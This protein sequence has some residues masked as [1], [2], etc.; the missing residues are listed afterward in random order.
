MVN[1]RTINPV[2]RATAIIGAVAALVAGV[3]FAALTSTAT[4]TDTTMSSTTAE[5]L[6][7]DGDSFDSTAPG[8]TV[9]DL[10]P[11][12]GSG[13]LPFYF[14]NN[15]GVALDITARVPALPSTSGITSYG[16]IEV[17]IDGEETGC[18]DAPVVT[19]LAALNA[20]PVT[21]P[22]NSLS[23]GAQGNSGVPGTEGNYTVAFDLDPSGVSGSSASVGAFNIEF[24]GTQDL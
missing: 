12:T 23:V 14:K 10:V 15:G 3:T 8:F 20:G 6:L 11:G 4:L 21:L 13:P 16:D 5:L 7:W 22:C 1:I 19:D 18:P 2:A 24:T 9:T 17:T